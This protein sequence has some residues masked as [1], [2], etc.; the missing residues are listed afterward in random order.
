VEEIST[1]SAARR[2]FT[3]VELLV[4]IAIIGILVALLLPAVQAAREAS[5]RTKCQNNLKQIGI[6]VQN[7]HDIFAALPAEGDDGPTACCAPDPGVTWYY[8]W[9]YHILPFLEQKNVFDRGEQDHST[10]STS[11]VAGY[12]CPTRRAI[13]LYKGNAK[14]D[15]AA[16]T[17]TSTTNG[18]FVQ[19]RTGWTRLSQIVDGTSQTL[20]VAESRVHIRYLRET[21]DCCSDNENA[22]LA[23]WSDDVGRKGTN[24]PRPDIVDTTLPS[25]QADGFFGSSHPQV[26]NGVLVDGSVRTIR[27]SVTPGVFQGFCI[28]N[29]GAIFTQN[30][31]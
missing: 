29:D 22:Y 8:N 5:R 6:A 16:N 11:V 28:K 9:T 20:L 10:I 2:G 14:S 31:L 4:V 13:Q 3:L 7:Y 15:Y 19:S 18:P 1:G 12:Y 24:A 23:G 25:S 27:Y 30:D 26:L 17:G 21:G